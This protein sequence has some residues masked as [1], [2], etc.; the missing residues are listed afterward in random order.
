MPEK[1]PK[2]KILRCCVCGERT[3]GRQWFNRDEG[4]GLCSKCADYV[5]QRET[6]EEIRENY[7]VEGIHYNVVSP[8]ETG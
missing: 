7:G 5:G 1:L 6:E 4:F 2:I 8:R 3:V